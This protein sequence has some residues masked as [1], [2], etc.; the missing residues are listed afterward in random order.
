V[1]GATTGGEGVETAPGRGGETIPGGNGILEI[2]PLL[3]KHWPRVRAIY[4][5]GLL[6]GNAT[7]ATEAPGWAKWDADHLPECR[8]A[9]H[10]GEQVAGWSALSPVSGR[11]VYAGVAEVSVYVAEDARG[12]GVGTH[13]LDALVYASESH[14]IWTL[15]AGVFPENEASL[16]IHAAAGFRVVGVRERLGQ[17]DGAWRDVVLLERR[18]RVVGVE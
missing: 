13:L 3:P 17:R 8:F 14:G 16:A 5:Q 15:Q 11:C 7:F 4:L 1:E 2:T 6:T 18:S 10:V 12:R 9:A